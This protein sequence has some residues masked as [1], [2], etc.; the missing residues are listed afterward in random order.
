[1]RHQIKDSRCHGE[2]VTKIPTITS[3]QFEIAVVY[4][5]IM[6]YGNQQDVLPQ[7]NTAYHIGKH[8]LLHSKVIPKVETGECWDETAQR[9]HF[10]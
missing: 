9:R 8:H 5:T 7:V 2:T 3:C 6:V 4:V 10:R 1:M